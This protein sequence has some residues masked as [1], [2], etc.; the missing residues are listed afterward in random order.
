[1]SKTTNKCFGYDSKQS[2]GETLVPELWGMRSTSPL[3]LLLDPL[4]IG[5]VVPVRVTSMG[6]IELFDH[7]TVCK[8]MTDVKLNGEQ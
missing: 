7:L 6:Q 3:P 1:M 8:Q 2:D 4:R 5:M